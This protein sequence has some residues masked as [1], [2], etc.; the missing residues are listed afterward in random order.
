MVGANPDDIAAKVDYARYIWIT[1][2]LIL[3]SSPLF[4]ISKQVERYFYESYPN[5]DVTTARSSHFLSALAV[6]AIVQKGTDCINVDRAGSRNAIQFTRVEPIKRK[7]SHFNTAV[8]S[9]YPEFI[10]MQF[11]TGGPRRADGISKFHWKV[12]RITEAS[13]RVAF[14]VPRTIIENGRWNVI[15]RFRQNYSIIYSSR[16]IQNCSI[17]TLVK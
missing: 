4:A 3:N 2:L 13:E 6:P 11:E 17:S 16:Y 12:N 5:R 15:A 14:C 10:T 9:A 8:R 1:S 7:W